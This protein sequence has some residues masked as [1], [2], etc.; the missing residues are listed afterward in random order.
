MTLACSVAA[1]AGGPPPGLKS[2]LRALYAA[3]G[4]ALGA[5]VAFGLP[6][7]PPAGALPLIALVAG[8]LALP[9]LRRS[10]AGQLVVDPAGEARFVPAGGEPSPPLR[11]RR[12]LRIG[13]WRW[14]SMAAAD[15]S[16]GSRGP[17]L[18][19][20]MR[21]PSGAAAADDAAG[22][23]FDAWLQWQRDRQDD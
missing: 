10:T 18:A 20:A 2:V 9:A 13:A 22:R 8:A 4:A 15:P 1:V 14:M 6:A 21:V 7:L 12:S 16:A 23:R 17:R 5:A 19:L 11:P 3:A